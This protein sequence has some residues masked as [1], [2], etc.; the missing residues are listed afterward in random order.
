M[1]DFSALFVK[2]QPGH[3]GDLAHL[4]RVAIE[5][6]QDAVQ[7]WKVAVV[8]QLSPSVEVANVWLTRDPVAEAI[9]VALKRWSPLLEALVV[10]E[11]GE[12]PV[13]VPRAAFGASE[14][15]DDGTSYDLE[16]EAH[17]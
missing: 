5:S 9:Q 6:G 13:Q 8:D 7:A 14:L 10:Q 2:E 15:R 16:A 12:P 3:G 11:R 1:Q 17:A 4:D